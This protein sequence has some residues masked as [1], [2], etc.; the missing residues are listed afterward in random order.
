[1]MA[2]IA[3]LAAPVGPVAAPGLD[4]GGAGFNKIN[5]GI[6]IVEQRV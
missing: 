5:P 6:D 2:S 1:M 3:E 4:P